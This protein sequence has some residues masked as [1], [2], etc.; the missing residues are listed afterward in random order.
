[1][2][3][4]P[5]LTRRRVPRP[6]KFGL[7]VT[8]VSLVLLILPGE[9][10][11]PFTALTPFM[12]HTSG[13]ANFFGPV[14]F[15]GFFVLAVLISGALITLGTVA[16]VLAA[17]GNRF[18]LLGAIAINAVVMSLLLGSPLGFSLGQD[19]GALSLYVFLSVC[20]LI[21][22]A[23]LVLLLSPTTFASWWRAPRAFLV[24]A[25]VTGVLLLPGAI[26][27][28]SLGLQVSSVSAVQPATPTPTGVGCG[29]H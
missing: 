15:L 29:G 26:G 14:L 1:M 11:L 19:P 2:P 8:A 5:A 18:G 22:A 17:L 7:G 4:N 9:M 6:L 24:T 3:D 23:A 16:V 27:L 12:P 25:I 21:P 20:A 13:C 10:G 28:V